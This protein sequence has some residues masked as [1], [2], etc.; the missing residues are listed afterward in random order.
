MLAALGSRLRLLVKL[1][2]GVVTY[3][4]RLRRSV[5]RSVPRRWV[6]IARRSGT[7]RWGSRE[8]H[9]ETRFEPVLM[10]VHQR[11]ALSVAAAISQRSRQPLRSIVDIGANIGQ[12]TLSMFEIE[13]GLRVLSLEPNPEVLEILS[14]NAAQVPM[15]QAD[16]SLIMTTKVELV[17]GRWIAENYSA[18]WDLVKIDVEGHERAVLAGISEL[19]WRF[20]L[21][22]VAPARGGIEDEGE[23]QL[24]LNEQGVQ[25]DEMLVIE[26]SAQ[27]KDVLVCRKA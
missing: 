18:E 13:S 16:E 8:I 4:P 26:D 20:L 1:E 5:I 25:I 12:F 7:T 6:D 19:R 9:Y 14:N 21:I 24:L 27:G 22:E 10:H 11:L 3:P 15:W 2:A 17:T 23:L